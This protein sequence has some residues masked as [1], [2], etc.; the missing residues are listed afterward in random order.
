MSGGFFCNLYCSSPSEQIKKSTA[1]R[2][3]SKCKDR[4]E[5]E[6]H[7]LFDCEKNETLRNKLYV[8]INDQITKAMFHQMDKLKKGQFL[9]NPENFPPYL[10]NFIAK[11]IH[12]FFK[13]A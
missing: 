7:F 9:L 4:V 13:T 2:T 5:D 3:C 6:Y 8:S 1:A 11:F 10:V 12:D